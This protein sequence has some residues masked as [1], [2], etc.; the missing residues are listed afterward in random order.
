[1]AGGMIVAHGSDV[2]TCIRLAKDDSRKLINE[3]PLPNRET[4]EFSIADLMPGLG[5]HAHE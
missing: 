3:N 4:R 5:N 1:M 2:Q